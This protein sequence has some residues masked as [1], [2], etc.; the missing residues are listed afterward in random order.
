MRGAGAS[1]LLLNGDKKQNLHGVFRGRIYTESSCNS[2]GRLAAGV[3]ITLP[4]DRQSSPKPGRKK[5]K[6]VRGR[7]W[8]DMQCSIKMASESSS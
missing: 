7:E 6:L 8:S 4:A 5:D 3:T 2:F 1:V